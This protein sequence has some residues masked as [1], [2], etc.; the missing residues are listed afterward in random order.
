LRNLE[1]LKASLTLDVEKRMHRLRRRTLA[2]LKTGDPEQSKTILLHTCHKA[3]EIKV[4]ECGCTERISSP[5]CSQMIE[6]GQVEWV[7]CERRNGEIITHREAV[8]FTAKA[9]HGDSGQAPNPIPQIVAELDI[10]QKRH[11]S[12]LAIKNEAR[13]AARKSKS[14]KTLLGNLRAELTPEENSCWSNEQLLHAVE[15]IDDDP[16]YLQGIGLTNTIDAQ[17]ENASKNNRLGQT[18]ES[19]F[20]K[21]LTNKVRLSSALLKA[22]KHFYDILLSSEGLGTRSIPLMPDAPKGKGVLVTGGMDDSKLDKIESYSQIDRRQVTAVGF[23]PGS[24]GLE[25]A[26]EG[27]KRESFDPIWTVSNSPEVDGAGNEHER[28]QEDHVEAVSDNNFK[29]LRNP[30][31]IEQNLSL[32]VLEQ[33]RQKYPE[34]DVFEIS[35]SR[36]DEERRVAKVLGISLKAAQRLLKAVE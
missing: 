21:S 7:R 27:G 8:A 3:G 22:S 1:K 23:R 32:S 34:K 24:G 19:D 5:T 17:L 6:A 9:E 12:V 16:N 35:E 13:K 30:E 14:I 10:V 15:H 20:Y 11:E 36:D 26:V 28:K 31:Q 33:P 25:Y 2:V 4:S 29:S 18:V